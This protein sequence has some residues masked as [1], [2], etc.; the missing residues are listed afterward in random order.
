MPVQ[1]PVQLASVLTAA[2]D[3]ARSH[4]LLNVIFLEA[5]NGDT[6][7]MVVGGEETVLGFDY[8]HLN[9]PYFA[10][11]G[12]DDG[13]HPVLTA[14]VSLQHHTEF[15]RKCVIAIDQGLLAAQEFLQT[16]ARPE[17]IT[18]QEV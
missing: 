13:V 9:P 17:C 15:P 16:G 12:S 18:W 3:E 5:D 1:T 8:G 10:S 14:Y 7:I 6:L 4:A 11:R 2:A